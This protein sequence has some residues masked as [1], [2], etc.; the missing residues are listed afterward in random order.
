MESTQD[1]VGL[2]NNAG[3]FSP[4]NYQPLDPTMGLEWDIDHFNANQTS[5]FNLGF[6]P[7]ETDVIDNYL[8]GIFS[9]HIPDSDLSSNATGLL[10]DYEV[11]SRSPTTR[12][13][14]QAARTATLSINGSEKGSTKLTQQDRGQK[15]PLDTID[16]VTPANPWTISSSAYAKLQTEVNAFSEVLPASFTLPSRPKLSRF[17]ASWMRGYHPHLPFLHIPTA[18]IDSMK[19]MLVLTLA[20]TGSFYG[21]EHTEGYP[22]YFLAKAMIVKELERR[23]IGATIRLLHGL[24]QYAELPTNHSASPSREPSMHSPSQPAAFDVELL[25]ALLVLIMT[26]SWLDGPFAQEALAMSS[27]LSTLTREALSHLQL[28]DDV[29][30]SWAKWGKAEERRRTIFAA[31][32]TLNIQ[33][34][35]FNVPPQLTNSE[36]KLL[37]PCSEAEFRAPNYNV[38]RSLRKA[39]TDTSPRGYQECLGRIL[40]GEPLKPTVVSE[41]G[42]YL[43]VQSLLMQIYWERQAASPLLSPSKSFASSTIALYDKALSAWQS[44]WDSAIESTLDPSTSA[45]GP[46]AFNSAA[47]LRLAHVHLGAGLQSHC[48]LL[49]RE[50]LVLAQAFEPSRNPL[51][52]R[53]EHLTKTVFHAVCALRIPVRVGIAFVARGRMGH[54]SAQHA[55]SNYACALLLTHW[56]ENM[57]RL[58]STEGVG[59]LALEEKRLLSTIEKLIEE[60]HLESSLGQKSQYPSRIRRLCI[61]ALR[62]W[63]Q[64]C[65]GIQVYEIVHVVGETLSIAAESIEKRLS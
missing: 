15:S 40:S 47:V 39:K 45:N 4:S 48:E 64:T 53:A 18:N 26:M 20:A 27:Q 3:L 19:P 56:L 23:R 33:T 49:T 10:H 42:N 37:L 54:W 58:V 11:V 43:L 25:Q 34:I 50:P 59:G 24:P 35:C 16:D 6:L 41:F 44:C 13:R 21:F 62:L 9:P 12:S 32:F 1:S 14:A 52:L 51:P 22:M 63:A 30:A 36:M 5:A 2:I 17:I 55:I 31:Y 61:A 46:V 7:N 29:D 65:K 57:F 60:T 8:Q 28:D 38:W